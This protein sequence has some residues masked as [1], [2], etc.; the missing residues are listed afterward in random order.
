[1]VTNFFQVVQSSLESSSSSSSGS[2]ILQTGIL[3]A[4]SILGKISKYCDITDYHLKYEY[5]SFSVALCQLPFFV[6]VNYPHRPVGF[7]AFECYQL[8]T[9]LNIR[10]ISYYIF[11]LLDSFSIILLHFFVYFIILIRY[12][13]YLFG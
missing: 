6:S 9:R 8:G 7:A 1:M 12:I 5:S 3:Q 4:I 2:K 11:L 13:I 10:L